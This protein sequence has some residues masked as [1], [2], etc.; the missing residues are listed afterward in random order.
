MEALYQIRVDDLTADDLGAVRSLFLDYIGVTAGGAS[1]ETAQVAART[2]LQRRRDGGRQP[3]IGTDVW[4]DPADAGFANAVAGHCLE[5]DDTHSGSS[6]HPGVVVFSAALAAAGLAGARPSLFVE[7]VVTGYEVMCRVGRAVDAAAHY[8]RHF[9]PTATAGHLAAAA[10]AAR[11]LGLNAGEATEAVGIA[12]TMAAGSLEFLSDGAW[13]KRLHPGL[14]VR[15]GLLATQLVAEGFHGPADGIGGVHGFL[16]A[17]TDTPHPELLLDGIGKSRLEIRNTSIKAHGC[18]R[19]NQGPIDAVLQIRAR[20]SVRAE[21]VD[22]IRVGV[23]TPAL[24]L[25]WNPPESKRHPASVVDAQFSLPYSVA[26]AMV[27]GRANPSEFEPV[28]EGRELQRLMDSVQ[29]MADPKLDEHY[30]D[31]WRCWVEIS[32][33]DGRTFTTKVD[34]PKGE[35][36]NPFTADDLYSKVAGLTGD[37]YSPARLE[38]IAA[39]AAGL[40]Q[41]DSM[42]PIIQLL[43]ADL[44]TL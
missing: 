42:E 32:L 3:L 29:C 35:P 17:Y 44:T 31:Q 22:S 33:T 10:T 15:N 43:V 18:C 2:L 7:G 8:R 39:K 14:A 21:D 25:V 26:I 19:Y 38:Q 23:V 4:A 1:T 34:E 36:G 9:H 5:F 20:E 12:C 28:R 27:E 41:G 13:T 24:T 40:P 16:A 6:L 37:V 11:I 30:P